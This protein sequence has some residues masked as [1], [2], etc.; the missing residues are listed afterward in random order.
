MAITAMS[1][2]IS[3]DPLPLTFGIEVE[4][5]LAFH[6]SIL[7]PHLPAGTAIIKDLALSIRLNLRQTTS[8]YL[9]TRPQ[10]NGWALTAPTDYPSPFGSGWH[11]KCLEVHGCRGYADEILRMEQAILKAQG[12]D[13][14]V[15]DGQGKMQDF[16]TWHLTTDTSLVGATPAQLASVIIEIDSAEW[17]SAPLELVSPPL[18]LDDPA[19][20][21]EIEAILGIIRGGEE[22]R[23]LYK[24]FTDP[25]CGL[26]VHI[27]LPPSSSSERHFRLGLLQHLAYITVIYE[28]VLSE[29][30]PASRRPGHAF[31]STDLASNR[32]MFYEEPD[33]AG[34]D[35][36]AVDSGYASDE[37][38]SGLLLD[39]P[40]TAAKSPSPPQTDAEAL[41]E[42]L[43][44]ALRMQKRA[45]DLIFA[46]D[47]SLQGLCKLMSSGGEKGR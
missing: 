12:K 41:Q 27:G 39:F 45:C 36:D 42:D 47:Q 16:S 21:A 11:N 3:S 19:S 38:S 40:T 37:S 13:V 29:L 1:S 7:T 23:K 17:D 10:Y 35:W 18:A 43:E 6:S 31:A 25:Y 14:T 26:H 44:F 22:E 5:I 20:F 34:V 33:Y 8:Q 32:D 24:A 46:P 30:H 4:H 2:P 15:H 9:L 28:H